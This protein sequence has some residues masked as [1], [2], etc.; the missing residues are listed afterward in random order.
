MNELRQPLQ[1]A[2]ELIASYREGLEAAPVAP[3]ASRDDVA[4]AL[5][6][7]L[8]DDPT[9]LEAVIDELVAGA[10]PGLMASAGPRY[11]GFVIGGSVDAA[12]IADLL[13]VGWD[14][15]A[16]NAALSPAALGF[17]D[18]AGNWLKELLHIPASAS[19]GFVTGGQAANNVGLAA[20]R[21]Q[22]LHRHG[23]DVGR[24]G[25]HGAPR[26]RVLAGAERHATI[27]RALRLLGLGERAL[28]EVPATPA[29]AMDP[30][31]FAAALASGPAGPTIVCAQAGN[32]NTG[33]CDDLTTIGP[34][35][36]A[37]GAWLHVDG[38]FGL[39]A[40]ASPS[41]Y[42]LVEG[43]D[44]ADSWACDG[45]KWLNVPYDAGYVF[46]ADPNVHATAMAYTASYLTGQVSGRVFG[47]GDFVAESSRR[48]RGFATW[49]ALRSLGRTGIAEL[50]D[51]CCRLARRFAERLDALEGVEVVN[52]VVLNQVLVRVGDDELTSEV[53][54]RVQEDGTCWLGATTWRGERLL[55]IS[56]SNW[57]TTEAD[58][59]LS[60]DAIANAR[61][62]VLAET[63]S[64]T[65]R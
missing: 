12:L 21:W 24:D 5:G 51:R 55:R 42:P 17:E 36:R 49:A 15:C 14:Q 57:S 34:A 63:R 25:L 52:D 45:H 62:A 23:W 13:T 47:G 41:T 27:D 7:P 58:V 46:C 31:A 10:Q 11:F 53:E 56:V 54:R 22:V 4:A 60:V 40:A 44:L 37:A 30:D 29:G 26:V 19:V 8:P 1:R 9:P 64:R 6:R 59:D 28:V 38:A 16:F 50:V 35:A 61:A 43:V 33:A 3:H 65:T 20:G 2:V 32:V 18:V 39:W 48:A